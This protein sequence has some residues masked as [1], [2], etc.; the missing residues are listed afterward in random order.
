M[1]LFLLPKIQNQNSFQTCDF[2]KWPTNQAHEESWFFDQ[3][4]GEEANGMSPRRSKIL[5]AEE[6]K[7]AGTAVKAYEI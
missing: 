1:Y 3:R 4:D 7:S 6:M 2:G 5:D